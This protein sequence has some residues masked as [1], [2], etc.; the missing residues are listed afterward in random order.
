VQIAKSN[1]FYLYPYNYMK[2]KYGK[3]TA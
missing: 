1:N 2:E 3:I